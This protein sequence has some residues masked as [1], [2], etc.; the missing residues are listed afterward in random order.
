[1]T[2][3]SWTQDTSDLYQHFIKGCGTFVG[4]KKLEWRKKTTH[5][6]QSEEDSGEDKDED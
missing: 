1:M 5:E 6:E 3:S 4:K 2:S